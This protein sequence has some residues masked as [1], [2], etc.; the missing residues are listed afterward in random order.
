MSDPIEQPQIIIDPVVMR[1]I[2]RVALSIFALIGLAILALVGCGPYTDYLWFAHDVRHPEVFQKGYEIRSILFA[3]AFVPTWGLIFFSLRQAFA[4]SLVYLRRPDSIGSVVVGNII[5]WLQA[6]GATLVRVISPVIALFLAS[7]FAGEWD[8]YL[9]ASHSQKFGVVDPTFGLDLGFFVFRLPWYRAIANYTFATLIIALV[10]TVG[11]YVGLQSLAA[12]AKIELSRPHIRLHVSLL[13]GGSLLALGAQSWL[14]VY[15]AGYAASGQFTGAGY[16]DMQGIGALQIFSVLACLGGVLAILGWKLGRPNQVAGTAAVILGVFYGLGIVG[17]PALIQKFVVSPNRLARELPFAQNA[18]KMTRYAYGL[19][20]IDVRNTDVHMAPNRS[21]I[22]ASQSTLDNMRLWDPEVLRQSF[23]GLQGIRPYYKFNDVDVDRYDINGRR[24]MVMLA[25][26]D[27]NIEG[28]NSTA[29]NW[30]NERLLFTH[31]YGVVVVPVN[32]ATPDGQPDFLAQ[33]IPQSTAPSLPVSEPRVYFSDFRTETND[34]TDEYAIVKTGEH[35]LDYQTN[36]STETHSWTGDRGIPIGGLLSRLAFSIAMQDGNLL[37][38][39]KVGGES[40]LLVHRNVLDRATRLFPF[41]Q[42]DGDPYLVI[43]GGRLVW[44]LDGYTTSSDVPY[45]DRG[46]EGLDPFNYIRNSVKVTIDAYT[47][48]VSGFAVQPDEPVLKA[49]REIYPGLIRDIS[50]LPI[51]VREHFRYPE[52]M[53][54]IQSQQLAQYHVTDPR[55]FLSNDDAWQISKERDLNGASADIKPYYVQMQLPDEPRAGFLLIRP[56]TPSGKSTMSGWLAAHS[57]PSD[58]GRLTLYRF[59]NQSPVAGPQ[60]MEA[61]FNSTP[62]ISNINRQYQNGQSDILVGNLLVV[63]I[64]QS[65]MYVEP[66][67]LKSKTTGITGVPRLFRVVLALNDRVVVGETYREAL[68]DLLGAQ[69]IAQSPTPSNAPAGKP[70]KPLNSVEI[71]RASEA[72]DLLDQADAALR[73]GQFGKFG[74]LQKQ[75]REILRTITKK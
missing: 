67:Y 9:L 26:R 33:G 54:A 45:S 36:S 69:S 17:Y 64:G 68:N 31:G 13:I 5:V 35:E 41:L 71:S 46:T 52:D 19:D 65:V 39:P 43:L 48:V 74:D 40:R 73:Q 7:G 37:F 61:N 28:L 44:I 10:L 70:S 23:E 21:E 66:L 3:I 24:T 29:R 72:L 4:L 14:K 60:L 6:K 16:A 12:L 47:G 75:A 58:Y 49:Y 38:S 62:A 30:T 63:P 8:T 34:P 53:F 51:G 2:S 27:V 1:R 32:A 15:E 18:I 55:A 11:L 50:E 56:F 59:V 57:D 42:F 22:S 25:P 20:K